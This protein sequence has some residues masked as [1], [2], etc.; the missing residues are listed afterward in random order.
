MD[1][2]TLFGYALK[3][4]N[5]VGIIVILMM[6]SG[7]KERVNHLVS[8]EDFA[9]EKQKIVALEKKVFNND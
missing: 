6:V 5:T 3:F 8:A 9:T 4:G 7:L 1:I 2:A